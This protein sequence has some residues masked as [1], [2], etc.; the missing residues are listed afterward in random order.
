MLR[1]PMKASDLTCLY[2]GSSLEL[3]VEQL[4]IGQNSGACPMCAEPFCIN[5]NDDDIAGFLDAE[6]IRPRRDGTP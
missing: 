6:E 4:V 1:G 3:K 2:C 5:L